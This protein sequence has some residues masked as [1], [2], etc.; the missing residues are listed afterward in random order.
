M[1]NNILLVFI[2]TYTFGLIWYR[3]SDNL[4]VDLVD[5]PSERSWVNQSNLGRHNMEDDSQEKN[6][7]EILVVCMYYMLTTLS[8]VGYGDLYPFSVAEKLASVLIMVICGM[9]FAL[10]LQSLIEAFTPRTE[11]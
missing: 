11:E 3:L 2:T 8:T 7:F 6:I 10:L 1:F 4:L 5:E 9:I